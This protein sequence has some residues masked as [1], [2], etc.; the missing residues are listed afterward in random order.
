MFGFSDNVRGPTFPA[1]LAEYKL[2]DSMGA[3]FFSLGAFSSFLSGMT[4]RIFLG[5]VSPF[6]LN[7]IS[8]AAIGFGLMGISLAPNYYLVLLFS[9]LLGSGMGTL[10]ISVNLIIE[11][12]A[13]TEKLRR[14][15]SGLHGCYGL[16]ALFAP[17]W[18][19]FAYQ[20]N[21]DWHQILLYASFGSLSVLL[22]S[23]FIKKRP[24]EM[25]NEAKASPLTL[26]EHFH[27]FLFALIMSFYVSSELTASS[28]LALYMQRHEGYNGIDAAH[29]V[30]LFFI[31]LFIGRLIFTL[32]IRLSDPAVI[33]GSSLLSIFFWLLGLWLHPFFITLTGLSLA[34]IFPVSMTYARTIYGHRFRGVTALTLSLISLFLVVMH[35]C[36]GWLT[37]LWNIHVAMHFAVLML[38]FHILLFKMREK[39][40]GKEEVLD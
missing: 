15:M 4:T 6:L 26:K 13:P 17:A 21:M 39:Y 40:F 5:G 18:V 11:S 34:P 24:V 14:L 23:F 12:E 16:A 33:L 19:A 38:I 32:Q 35:Q 36:I 27:Q 30:T 22:A 20:V 10:G 31:F 28:R 37:D 3:L 29:Y 1:I 7:R 9:L 25:Q 8:L 2:S